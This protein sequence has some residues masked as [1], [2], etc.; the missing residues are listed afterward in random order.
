MLIIG[1]GGGGRTHMVS[2]PRDFESRASANSTTP[3]NY[4]VI[5][6]YC[7]TK[8][9]QFK[10]NALILFL[11]SAKLIN[12]EKLVLIDGNSLLNRAYYATPV[13]STK[14]GVP[15]NA[16]SDLLNLFLKS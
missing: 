15:T 6:L 10:F 2:L 1:A 4:V 8:I 7:F 13:F 3:A 16:I 12:M 11:K 5:I 14:N 9:K